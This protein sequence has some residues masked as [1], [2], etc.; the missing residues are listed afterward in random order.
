[1]FVSKALDVVLPN[2]EA[3]PY[4]DDCNYLAKKRFLIRNSY[5]GPG[6]SLKVDGKKVQQLIDD[7]VRALDIAE[8]MDQREVTYKRFLDY[9][10]KFKTERARTALVKNN[11]RQIIKEFAPQIQFIMKN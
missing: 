9:A 8:L 11:A 3:D 1:M 2:K 7:H 6:Q 5:E 10:A 4:I